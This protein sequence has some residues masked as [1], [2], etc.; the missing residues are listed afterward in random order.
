MGIF[1]FIK[2]KRKDECKKQPQ[3]INTTAKP[4]ELEHLTAEGELPW[5]WHYRHK[6][7]IEKIQKEYSCFLDIWL[8]SRSKSS[9]ELYSALKSFV[10]YLEDL[11]SLCISKGE[12]YELWFYEILASKNYIEARKAE[13]LS[14]EIQL[15]K[16]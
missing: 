4:E 16:E 10:I 9:K 1:D 7:F 6:E 5:G 15:K 14:L 8:D 2:Y 12:C 13:L 11:E 3:L